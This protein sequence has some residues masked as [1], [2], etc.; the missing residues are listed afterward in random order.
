[1]TRLSLILILP[2]AACS[3]YI[4]DKASA[5]Y[6]PVRAEE[7]AFLPSAPTG[8]IFNASAKGLFVSD[9]RAAVVGDMLTVE[10]TE[11]F[12]ATKSQTASGARSS[13]Y[14]TELPFGIDSGQLTGSAAQSFTG[15]GGAAQSNSLTGL[16]T[17]TVIRVLPNGDL[18]ISGQKRLTLNNGNEYVRLSGTVR[19]ED[20]SADNIVRSER[21]A[22]AEIHYVGA[23]DVADTGKSGW[24]HR[25][26][27]IASPL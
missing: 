4:E 10:F 14:E 11:Q 24:M 26:L 15:R 27:T 1:M 22:N 25:L 9:R 7:P 23:G 17:V 13:S 3:T 12:R 6:A 20:I 19:P 2:L 16:L 21:I 8:G 5:A 18:E